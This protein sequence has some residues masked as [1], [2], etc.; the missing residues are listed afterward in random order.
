MVTWLAGEEEEDHP[1]RRVAA[2]AG[3]A[4]ACCRD[5]YLGQLG[6]ALNAG[7]IGIRVR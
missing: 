7:E 3:A 4:E 1:S 2:G 6:M 5:N